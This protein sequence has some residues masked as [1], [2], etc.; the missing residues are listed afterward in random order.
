MIF[1]TTRPKD[2][3]EHYRRYLERRLRE[4]FELEGTPVRIVFKKKR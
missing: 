4:R 3:P 1:F 2:V